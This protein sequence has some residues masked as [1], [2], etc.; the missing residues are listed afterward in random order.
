M[1]TWP[2]GGADI[3]FIDRN[4]SLKIWKNA[5]KTPVS[6]NI[7]A[8]SRAEASSAMNTAAKPKTGGRSAF[9][10]DE[11]EVS[12]SASEDER[13][14]S[15][16]AGDD[17]K[18]S[19]DEIFHANETSD[20]AQKKPSGTKGKRS[21]RRLHGNLGD[22]D[23]DAAVDNFSP[24]AYAPAISKQQ[25]RVQQCNCSSDEGIHSIFGFDRRAS[26]RGTLSGK[27]EYN[28]ETDIVVEFH[29][30]V[31]N[32]PIRFK[33]PHRIVRGCLGD[34]GVI[35]ASDRTK[36]DPPF[37]SFRGIRDQGRESKWEMALESGSVALA[38]GDSWSAVAFEDRTLRIITASG[39][40]SAFF[41]IPGDVVMLAAR[42]SMLAV[43]YHAGEATFEGDQNIVVTVY[44][45]FKR[46]QIISFPLALSILAHLSWMAFDDNGT[47]F[48]F[49]SSG[50]FRVVSEDFGCAQV[51]MKLEAEEK[52]VWPVD[53]A[54]EEIF[55]VHLRS[56][57]MCPT[58]DTQA[59][60]YI[61]TSPL[62]TIETQLTSKQSS[63]AF[64]SNEG[65]FIK[66]MALSRGVDTES[67][68]FLKAT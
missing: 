48:T 8:A 44:D 13:S 35:L 41:C 34:A 1:M 67:D 27:E 63:A 30:K 56:D 4:G 65:N 61:K 28:A 59:S 53:I 15:E 51:P 33:T 36:N 16:D 54:D 29:D 25:P 43:A 62:I 58:T 46:R 52:R 14:G 19:I 20:S 22:N 68:A 47:L 26:V 57:Q 17:M 55:Y 7:S 3:V 39:L 2:S 66:G 5:A 12:G 21:K 40:V 11:A 9:I 6:P 32:R 24:E 64:N 23:S 31:K 42:N 49:D 38:V 37:L 18:D 50:V 60:P 45:V 10:D